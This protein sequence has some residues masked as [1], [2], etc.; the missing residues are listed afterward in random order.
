MAE[1]SKPSS[2]SILEAGVSSRAKPAARPSWSMK[3]NSA[4]S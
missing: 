3:G 2:F 1:A 4:L